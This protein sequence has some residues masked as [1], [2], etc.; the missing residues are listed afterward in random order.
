MDNPHTSHGGS[1][2]CLTLARG[3]RGSVPWSGVDRGVGGNTAR[4]W[5]DVYLS[6][7]L[8]TADT[9]SIYAADGT[10][11]DIHRADL[12]PPPLPSPLPSSLIHDQLA[13]GKGK[14]EKGKGRRKKKRRRKKRKKRKK[15]SG[16]VFHSTRHVIS[17]KIKN[18]PPVPPPPFVCI[19]DIH[20]F[21]PHVHGSFVLELPGPR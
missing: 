9:Y 1:R 16:S 15:K 4:T 10:G 13:T 18:N 21:V 8:C 11:G 19:K 7:Y 5:V 20:P 12:A 3:L 17:K 2:A 6:I 14:K